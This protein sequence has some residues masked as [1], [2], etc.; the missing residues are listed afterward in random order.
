VEKANTKITIDVH[1]TTPIYKQL[2]ESIQDNIESNEYQDGDFVPSMNELALE[3]DISKE[4]V[5]KA[6]TILREKGILES[7]QGKGFY[8]NSKRNSKIK[9]LLLFDKLS[10]YKQILYNSFVENTSSSA[11][12]TIRLHNQDP[13]L[14]SQFIEE[15]KDQYDYYIITPHFSLQ[16]QVQKSIVQTLKKVPNRKLIVLDK[17][18]DGLPGNFGCIYQD[19]EKDV[20]NGLLQ[21]IDRLREFQMLDILLLPGS[22]YGP[23]IIKGI[24]KFCVDYDIQYRIFKSIEADK[25]KAGHAFLII[26]GQ[27]DIE[28]INLTHTAKSKDFAI[29]K[30]IGIIAYNESPINEIILNGLSVLSTDFRQMGKLAA[31]MIG[32]NEF[33]KIKCDFS[34]IKRGTF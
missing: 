1:S 24:K 3:L 32:S 7:V 23:L 5:K 28:L 27:L 26:N 8:I 17:F 11:E 16:A 21:G 31:E 9:I 15:Y 4:T 29:G 20:Y 25:I 33:K 13:V 34:L 10:T 2:V 14:F 30:D 6:Y 19:F 22:L 18:V 12:I